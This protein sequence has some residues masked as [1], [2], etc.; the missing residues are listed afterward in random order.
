MTSE[1]NQPLFT[2]NSPRTSAAITL[3]GVLNILGVFT[4][5]S[6]SPSIAS[7]SIRNCQIRGILISPCTAINSNP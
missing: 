6:R 7:S 1:L 2:E 5:A 3:K 4:A